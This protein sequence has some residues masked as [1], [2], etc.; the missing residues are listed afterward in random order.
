[1]NPE[2][3][4]DR[5]ASECLNALV[6]SNRIAR[7]AKLLKAAAGRPIRRMVIAYVIGVASLVFF[8]WK[9]TGAALMTAYLLVLGVQAL[10]WEISSR[11]DAIVELLEEW[12][13]RD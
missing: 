8:S 12:E 9:L 13:A 1:M 3:T 11:V 4:N 6:A 10:I 5:N 7:R 2:P